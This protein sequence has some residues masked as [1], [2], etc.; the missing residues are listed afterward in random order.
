LKVSLLNKEILLEKITLKK[1]QKVIKALL[2]NEK[3]KLGEIQVILLRDDE[4]L[5]INKNFLRHNYFTDIIAFS[6]N[7]KDRIYGDIFISIDSVRINSLRFKTSF[8]SE[9][10]RV[11][12]HGVLHLAGYEDKSTNEKRNM[13]RKENFYLEKF[14]TLIHE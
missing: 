7:R 11:I 13:R 1:I 2:E 9:I 4:I 5:E 3:K 6:Y 12:I 10:Y 14:D 8:Y